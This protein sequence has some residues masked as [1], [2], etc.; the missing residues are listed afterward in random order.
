MG[1]YKDENG[2]NYTGAGVLII[3]DYYMKNGNMENCIILVRNKASGLYVDF[4]GVYELKDDS[5]KETAQH[6]LREES[7]NLFNL[8]KD[9]FVDY[10][11]IP[12]DKNNYYRSY[13]LKINGISRKYF[14]KNMKIIDNSESSKRYWKETDDI[15][16]VPI[17]NI[18]FYKLN[19]RGTIIVK[20]IEGKNI[21][22]H[23]RCKKVLYYAQN[24]ILKKIK[25]KPLARKRDIITEESDDFLNGTYSYSL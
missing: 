22:L 13:I 19:K 17:K 8:S 16:H 6:E 15:V 3:E 5:L 24:L 14:R 23:R 21:K 2:R 10:V 18:D 20:D 1:I 4:G 12:A 11:D 25:E 7:R 9:N